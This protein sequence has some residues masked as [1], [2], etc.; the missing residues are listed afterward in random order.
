MLGKMGDAS[1]LSEGM[2]WIWFQSPLGLLLQA[3]LT[4][5]L[6]LTLSLLLWRKG[7]SRYE[8][9]GS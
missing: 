4:A 5:F 1:V 2:D 9:A 6:F 8:S 3:A 7:L